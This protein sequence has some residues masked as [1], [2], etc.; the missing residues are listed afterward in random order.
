MSEAAFVEAG[1]VLLASPDL[2]RLT[3]RG[4]MRPQV[5]RLA[6]AFQ[7]EV[8]GVV[9]A[10]GLAN[11]LSV[12]ARASPVT[13]CFIVWCGRAISVPVATAVPSRLAARKPG[14]SPA[15]AS[16]TSPAM[17]V[18][19]LGSALYPWAAAAPAIVGALAFGGRWDSALRAGA[20]IPVGVPAL[21]GKGSAARYSFVA[22]KYVEVYNELAMLKHA[23]LY[24]AM[25]ITHS[26][27]LSSEVCTAFSVCM[28]LHARC[29]NHHVASRY[30]QQELQ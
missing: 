1:P 23:D 22:D 17:Q 27:G 28:L 15:R 30:C 7:R 24:K 9:T 5:L 4:R 3:T 18:V 16:K 6:I 20:G 2:V 29:S 14:R 21:A 10:H 13:A 11:L 19:R 8:M 26:V 12:K 25:R